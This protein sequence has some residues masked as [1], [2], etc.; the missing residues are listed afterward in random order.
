M[1][2]PDSTSGSSKRR[3]NWSSDCR[4][5][6]R[7]CC[8][9]SASRRGLHRT[10]AGAAELLVRIWPD[11]IGIAIPPGDLSAAERKA[12]DRYWSARGA[13]ATTP[14]GDPM[15]EAARQA[16]EAAWAGIATAYGA[17]RAGW[18]VR[19]SKPTNWD[20]ET[21]AP[22]DLPLVPPAPA[23]PTE[24]RIARAEV[25]PD[26]FVITGTFKGQTLPDAIGEAIPDD[27]ALA[28]DPAHPEP[29]VDR[30]DTGAL[31]VCRAR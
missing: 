24:P 7:S 18:I 12:G 26:R 14:A 22:H 6:I 1:R 3:S 2:R 20:D 19:E 10:P 17:Y 16:Y 31:V 23:P 11:D 30:D 28:P 15:A 5:A 27:L 21:N 9:P 25:L 4:L 13:V 29:L 8:F